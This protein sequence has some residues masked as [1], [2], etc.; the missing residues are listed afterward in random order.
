MLVRLSSM[1]CIILLRKD[2][3]DLCSLLN[4][5]RDENFDLHQRD[6]HGQTPLHIITRPWVNHTIFDEIVAE[7]HYSK[8]VL[9][10]SPDNLGRTV[11]CQLS[12]ANIVEEEN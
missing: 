11:I 5:L 1:L 4:R 2:C 3:L 6:D 8:I 10:T 9:P 7:L 12:Q